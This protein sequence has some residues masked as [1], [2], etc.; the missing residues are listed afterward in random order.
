MPVKRLVLFLLLACWA[1]FGAAPQ[2]VKTVCS[3]Y[4]N[5][6]SST[7]ACTGTVATSGDFIVVH[8]GDGGGYSVT[9]VIETGNAN[10]YFT[11]NAE[12]SSGSSRHYAQ[13]VGFAGAS[14]SRTFT[15]TISSAT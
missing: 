13:W 3:N 11:A 9:S 7:I 4:G 8:V 15:A 10:G 1:V 12:C 14:G 6:S 2:W 5:S